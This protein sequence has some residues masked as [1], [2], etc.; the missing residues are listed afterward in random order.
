MHGRRTSELVGIEVES[1]QL[2][3]GAEAQRNCNNTGVRRATFECDTT[4]S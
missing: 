1:L 3:R 2:V 4:S